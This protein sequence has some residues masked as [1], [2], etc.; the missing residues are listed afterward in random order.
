MLEA[1]RFRLWMHV[2]P[3]D[4][5]QAWLESLGI[6]YFH[7]TERDAFFNSHDY[8]VP[9]PGIALPSELLSKYTFIEELDL[10]A[11]AWKSKLIA[12]TGTVGKTSTV[13]LLSQILSNAG[14]SLAT[15]GNIGTG[16]L[17]LVD[18]GAAYGLLELSSF[19]LERAKPFAP[20]IAVI[21]NLY[22]NHL[23]RHGTL[24]PIS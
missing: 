4:E 12:V 9:S 3:S 15:G 18:E 2:E 19:Q 10:F 24:E 6:S 23:D 16:M 7:D 21:T 14:L 17:D 5:E 1:F 20:D 11:D 22:P 13:H 8:I